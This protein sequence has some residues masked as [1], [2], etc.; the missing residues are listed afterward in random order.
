VLAQDTLYLPVPR[1]GHEEFVLYEDGS[2][3]YRSHLCGFDYVAPGYYRKHFGN[4]VFS[5]DTTRC[6][7]PYIEEFTRAE[8]QDSL[9]LCFYE[10]PDK[11]P[12]EYYGVIAIGEKRFGCNGDSCV[13]SLHEV[14]ERI[15][16]LHGPGKE[17]VFSFNSTTTEIHLYIPPMMGYTCGAGAIRILKKRCAGYLRKSVV[18][19][20]NQEK[21][22][23]RGQR[24]VV[25][26]YYKFL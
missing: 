14:G 9:L 17:L 19:D 23:K 11:T 25:R 13:V 18:Y 10:M 3:Y 15:L 24:R 1:L 2:F 6:P 21:P 5:Y 4:Y 16:R 26:E 12:S 8:P 7:L 22:W 20:E